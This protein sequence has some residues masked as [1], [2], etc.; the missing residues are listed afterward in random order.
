MSK[1]IKDVSLLDFCEK[2]TYEYGMETVTGRALPD[3]RDGLKPVH[4]RIL[5]AMKGLNL[6]NSGGTKKSA[7]IVGET[8][9]KFHPHGDL[10]AYQAMVNMVN[11]P[12]P[13]VSKQGNFGDYESPPA[14]SRYTEVKLSKYAEDYLLDPDYLAV[15]PMVSNY[16]GEFQEPVYLPSKLP[17]LLING[18]EG[19]AT[20]CVC[21]VPS[22]TKKSVTKIVRLGLKGKK[23]TS[24][25]CTKHLNF[26]FTYGGEE[27]N[28][29][30]ELRSYFKTGNGSLYFIP[31]YED[32]DE[33]LKIKSISPRF[34]VGQ[35]LEK[36]AGIKGVSEVEDNRES[37]KIEF[38]IKVNKRNKNREKILDKIKDSIITSLPCQTT[39]TKRHNDGESA[40][41]F[42][43][44]I[45]E[46]LGNWIKY[47]IDLEEKVVKRL[48]KIEKE[49]L[50]RQEWLLFAINHRKEI[51]QSLEKKNPKKFLMK[52]L[53]IEENLADFIL[54]LK[55]RNLAKLESK[56]IKDKIFDH[57]GEIKSL[58]DDLK[59]I[60]KRIL[61]QLEEK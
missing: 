25:L 23:I 12:E 58:K 4:R 44:N 51:A 20:G 52:S 47:R 57:K 30:H 38:L 7:R 2:A 50:L 10:S 43:T 22:F 28:E 42:K 6:Y 26:K 35:K 55:V 14:A 40:D 16:D 59:N 39:I 61:R 27:C 11:L 33:G 32:T 17:N 45:P 60:E 9:G 3:L 8:L 5:F 36:L 19:I 41:F 56:K 18:S 15:V 49:K 21:L 37:G 13:L 1:Q 29:T 34:R 24:K 53:K 46:F 31:D 54:D 48:E